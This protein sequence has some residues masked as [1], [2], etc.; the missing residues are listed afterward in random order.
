MTVITVP[1]P[2]VATVRTPS[3]KSGLVTGVIAAVVTSV[4]AVA[5]RALGI[6]LD[7]EGEAIPILGFAQ[8]VLLDTVIGIVLAR[9]LA[10]STFIMTTEPA[11]RSAGG[12]ASSATS[13]RFAAET[14]GPVLGGKGPLQERRCRLRP[15][16][17]GDA[18]RRGEV[19]RGAPHGDLAQQVSGLLSSGLCHLET[20]A[21]QHEEDTRRRRGPAPCRADGPGPAVQPRS[22]PGPRHP[23]RGHGCR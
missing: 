22:R 20:G 10:R 16:V 14:L 12:Q 23:R 1:E 17:G 15:V 6:P 7:I 3:W 8:M 21:E 5:A 13:T 19:Q 18:E 2:T 11:A 9:R 4:V